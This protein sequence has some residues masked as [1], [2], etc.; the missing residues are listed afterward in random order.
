MSR[1]K[2]TKKRKIWQ[3]IVAILIFAIGTWLVIDSFH[4][5]SEC[6][7]VRDAYISENAVVEYASNVDMD[8]KFR[9]HYKYYSLSVGATQS[10][11]ISYDLNGKDC[12]KN[13]DNLVV[14]PT[15]PYQ[16]GQELTIYLNPDNTAVSYLEDDLF[17]PTIAGIC[18]TILFTLGLSGIFLFFFCKKREGI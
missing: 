18:L 9:R 13:Y 15:D 12:S 1:E 14:D 4:T 6:A 11:V 5:R 3:L 10:I 7:E 16:V 2:K 17:E 8:V